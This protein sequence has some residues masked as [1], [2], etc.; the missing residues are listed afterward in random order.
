MSTGVGNGS[1]MTELEREYLCIFSEGR[2]VFMSLSDAGEWISFEVF[3]RHHCHHSG[4]S[5]KAKNAAAE[6]V[7][8]RPEL[9]VA[10]DSF[11]GSSI[12]MNSDIGLVDFEYT[13]R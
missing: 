2:D 1:R 5:I 13:G 12:G 9:A 6:V 3:Q 4:V 10:G 8:S 7:L 11:E